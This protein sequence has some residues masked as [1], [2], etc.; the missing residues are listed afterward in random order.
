LRPAADLLPGV[1][2]TTVPTS[3]RPPLARIDELDGLRGIL[4]L[5]VAILHI[6]SW[7][8]LAP[9]AFPVPQLI[10]RLWNESSQ[11][12][13]DTFIIL[14]GFV[15]SFLIHSRPQSY[16]Q[17][18]TG[19]FFR[20]YPVYFICLLLGFCSIG[21]FQ[22]LLHHVSWQ[23]TNYFQP[24]L[25]PAAD[26]QMARPY[27]HL[28]AHLTL[29]FG[30]IPE[31]ILPNASVALLG[32]AWSITLEWQYYLV[33]P[34]LAR[35]VYSRAALLLLGLV[36]AGGFILAHF[37]SNSFLPLKLP[38]FLVGI[39]SFHL[40]ALAGR[41]KL[42]FNLAFAAVIVLVIIIAFSSQWMA[43]A[44]WTLVM[45]CLLMNQKDE[46]PGSDPWARGLARLRRLLLHPILQQ[47]GRISYP[48]YLIHLP[49]IIFLLLFLLHLQ[50]AITSGM[51]LTLLLLI[52]LPLILLAAW[53][54]HQLV[55]KPL[56]RYG[57]RFTR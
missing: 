53:L 21:P 10:K 32:P 45:A 18:M 54:L 29:L 31:K 6:I 13:V 35:L 15:I 23:A 37:W 52:G 2:M 17:F 24:W 49:I 22:Y 46:A 7:C 39:G 55:E 57:A 11:G 8:G 42:P 1:S 20:I 27:T 14:S 16:R 41:R 48:V 44:L 38:F 34:L 56:M 12:A 36:G 51:A 30:V 28:L 5:W 50:P 47:L 43:L 25:T 40:Y 4:A 33:A 3:T 19:R 9:L 26:A